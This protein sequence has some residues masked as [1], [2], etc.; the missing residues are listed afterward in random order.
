MRCL[1]LQIAGDV[2]DGDGIEWAFLNIGGR[3]R[4]GV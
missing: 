1:L 2:D 3:E 4:M